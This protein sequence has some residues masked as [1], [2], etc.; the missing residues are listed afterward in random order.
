MKRTIGAFAAV[1]ALLLAGERG[2]GQATT[3]NLVAYWPMNT[4]GA[5]SPDA[6]GAH[7]LTNVG[8]GATATTGFVAGA[9]AC[10][11]TDYFTAADAATLNFGTGDFSVAAWIRPTSTEDL[12]L[13][14]KWDNAQ[15]GWLFDINSNAGGAIQ[16]GALRFRIDTNNAN[17]TESFDHVVAA[18]LTA[19]AWQHV[20]ATVDRTNREIRLY[21]NG[22][23]VGGVGAIPAAITATGTVSNTFLLG[24]GSIPSAHSA[25]KYFTGSIDEVRLYNRELTAADVLTLVAPLPPVL[26]SPTAPGNMS[27]AIDWDPVA[28]AV[29][30]QVWVSTVSG[31]GY[32]SFGA[33]TT[34]TSLTV[35][36]LTNGT[37][38]YFVV[39]ADNGY[40]D[41]AYSNQVTG[42]PVAPPP[43]TS[44]HEEGLLDDQCACGSSVGSLLPTLPAILAGLALLGLRRRR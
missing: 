19:N 44:G 40:A 24:I 10:D 25:G 42:T 21:R 2:D 9:A 43:R 38:Y 28:G 12:R 8:S 30:Y 1:L 11:S 36:G 6:A 37:P 29:N 4:V 15:Q 39:T 3:T 5:T 31:S 18:G 17:T 35:T 14:N 20:A 13:I 26:L 23:Q 7:T 32:L 27:V 16:V 34:A 22:V 33:P 41:S